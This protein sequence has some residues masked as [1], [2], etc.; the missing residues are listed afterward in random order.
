MD[1]L[2]AL[3][4]EGKEPTVSTLE[5]KIV[6]AAKMLLHLLDPDF[7]LNVSELA[8]Q[9]GVSRQSLYN[10]G[11][12]AITVLAIACLK[13]KPGPKIV[14]PEGAEVT[15]LKAELQ[16]IQWDKDRL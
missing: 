15:R 11:W 10:W 13:T 12:L 3:R 5:T 9:V 16:Q 7:E 1:I 4:L 6:I 8:R 2:D 14:E